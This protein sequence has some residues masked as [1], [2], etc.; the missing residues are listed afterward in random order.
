MVHIV[1]KDCSTSSAANATNTTTIQDVI[2]SH[3]QKGEVVAIRG[4]GW[5]TI[6]LLQ[7]GD[8]NHDNANNNAEIIKCR[9]TQ[10]QRLAF[11]INDG[12][13]IPNKS[14]K[15]AASS[16]IAS[17]SSNS[18]EDSTTLPLVKAENDT[19]VIEAFQ[20]GDF[21]IIV[22]PDIYNLDGALLQ[23]ENDNAV[24]NLHLPSSNK[25]PNEQILRQVGHHATYEKWVV[26]SDL[27]CSPSTLD[28]CL[29]VLKIVHDT[30]VQQPGKCGVLFLGDFW[31][32]RGTLRV[33]CLN[34]VLDALSSWT[35]PMV[36]IPGNH[37]QVTL[38]GDNHGLTP[39]ANA[40][41]VGGKVPG[42]L[43]FSHPTVFRNALFVPHIRDADV[44][45][46][47]MQSKEAKAAKALFLHT[48]IKGA[49][50]NDLMVSTTG[51]SPSIFPSQKH[52]YS[53]HFH[54][55]H[56]IQI[57]TTKSTSSTF[58]YMGS[59]YQTSLAEAHQQKLLTVL[60]ANWECQERVPISVGRR[61]FKL[62]SVEELENISFRD[63]Q[64]T[65]DSTLSEHSICVKRGDRIVVNLPKTYHRRQSKLNA[66]ELEDHETWKSRVQSLRNQGLMVEVRESPSGDKDQPNQRDDR[67]NGIPSFEELSP[68]EV[69]KAYLQDTTIRESMSE[70]E[71]DS[72]VQEGSEILQEIQDESSPFPMAQGRE[73]RKDLRLTSLSVSGFGPFEDSIEYPLN[74]RGMVLLRGEFG[75]AFCSYVVLAL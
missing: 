72:L 43:I 15:R 62:S 49:M 64:E 70:Q 74:D 1:P 10:L 2:S 6:R 3:P 39:L 11:D 31:H 12:R 16:T 13:V 41:R 17:K 21:P 71:R 61:H 58:E 33:D 34:A 28:T 65:L 45:K 35:V 69:W 40:Y 5:Y 19:F 55:P 54:K 63:P 32:H 24:D 56:S 53:G 75:I 20:D 22:P 51:L 27:H 50:M 46:S 48:E 68:D 7:G 4:C 9:G 66:N 73:T 36:M 47:V 67:K 30:A 42:P 18:I 44:M 25:I 26:F 29:E 38:G 59:P 52:I 37:D 23:V 57:S 60:D 14:S 8:I